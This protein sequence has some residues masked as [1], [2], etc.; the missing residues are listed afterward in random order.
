MEENTLRRHNE[1]GKLTQEQINLEI[2]GKPTSRVDPPCKLRIVHAVCKMQ[3]HCQSFTHATSCNHSMT[4]HERRRTQSRLALHCFLHQDVRFQNTTPHARATLCVDVKATS[5]SPP[6]AHTHTH[7][8][9]EGTIRCPPRQSPPLS[10]RLPP[11]QS[12]PQP[13]PPIRKSSQKNLIARPLPRLPL[14]VPPE[15]GGAHAQLD[16]P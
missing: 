3:K 8:H 6:N 9:T 4:L 2:N 5:E 11:P 1:R 14:R 12:L 10:A 13:P 7:T 15:E 16:P